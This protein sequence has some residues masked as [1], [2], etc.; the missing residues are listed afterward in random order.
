MSVQAIQKR[1]G[2]R[3]SV[4]VTTISIS[5]LPHLEH[6][7]VRANRARARFGALP[8]SHLGGIGLD[9]MLAFLAPNDQPAAGGGSMAQRHGR[10][11]FGRPDQC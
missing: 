5:R 4:P 2:Y 7:P 11:M 1:A 3:L 8:S 6:A 10:A 9:L